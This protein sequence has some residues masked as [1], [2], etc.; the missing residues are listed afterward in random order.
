VFRRADDVNCYVVK[1]D[2]ESNISQK[3]TSHLNSLAP[4]W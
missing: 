4:E 3:S 2:E 1:D